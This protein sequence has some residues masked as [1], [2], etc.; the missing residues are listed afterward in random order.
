MSE[1]FTC[2]PPAG[3]ASDAPSKRWNIT[4]RRRAS[5]LGSLALAAE[6]GD[7][8]L[9]GAHHRRP[10]RGQLVA[11]GQPAVLFCGQG[12]GVLGLVERSPIGGRHA[13]V[14]DLQRRLLAEHALAT[15]AAAAAG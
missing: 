10:I 3:P 7:A 8:V 5:N 14:S 13:P 11:Q 12:L 4:S 6:F 15:G 1:R 9:I 2:L